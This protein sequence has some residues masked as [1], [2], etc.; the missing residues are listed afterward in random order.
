M[1]TTSFLLQ[2]LLFK[3]GGG[4]GEG[5][6][7]EGGNS[8]VFQLLGGRDRLVYVCVCV[9]MCVYV[10]VCVCICVY[11]CV[12]ACMCVCVKGC[13]SFLGFILFTIPSPLSPTPAKEEN[14]SI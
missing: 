2:F 6:G 13:F 12:C 10:C 3:G 1:S 5:A 4:G 11:V 9:C 7:G 8:L 14:L